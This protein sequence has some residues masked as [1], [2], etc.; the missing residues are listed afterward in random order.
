[1]A[2]AKKKPL[3]KRNA[4]FKELFSPQKKY[5]Y[6]ENSDRHAFKARA[7]RFQWVNCWWLAEAS[8]L[9]YCD[10]ATVM[11]ALTTAPRNG[12]NAAL[13]DEAVFFDRDGTQGFVAHNKDLVIVAFRG[14]LI[15]GLEKPLPDAAQEPPK[16]AKNAM[17]D[18]KKFFS[19]KTRAKYFKQFSDVFTDT[20]LLLVEDPPQPGKVHRGFK[21]A[22]DAV[23]QPSAAADENGDAAASS[24]LKATLD[25]IRARGKRK[26]GKEPALWFTG[27]SLGAALATLAAN[28]YKNVQ[29]V[30]TFGSP[31]VGDADFIQGFR[32]PQY[33]RIVN[34]RDIVALVP[35]RLPPFFDYCHLAGIRK[36]TQSKPNRVNLETRDNGEGFSSSGYDIL[37]LIASIPKIPDG[38]LPGRLFDHC[39]YIYVAHSWNLYLKSLKRA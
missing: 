10:R 31:R 22:L 39:P 18:I 16:I 11:K 38:N 20:N 4:T 24:G 27:H 34:N 23:W 2:A 33:Y 28:R 12:K 8:M 25:S 26:H 35:P 19:S 14:T 36:I 17:A 7:R 32:T 1:M 21:Q 29:G 5:R 15:P 3:P 30:Y 37:S 6:F 9:A 13:F